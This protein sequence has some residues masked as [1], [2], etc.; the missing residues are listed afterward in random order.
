MTS[1]EKVQNAMSVY[2]IQ[3]SVTFYDLH[4]TL[5]SPA[6]YYQ[7]RPTHFRVAMHQLRK[8]LYN[9]SVTAQCFSL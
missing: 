6:V 1:L 7:K 8:H 5:F 9:A 2:E 3:R 4:A